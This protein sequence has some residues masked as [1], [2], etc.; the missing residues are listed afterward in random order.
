MQEALLR[1]WQLAP[2]CAGDGRPNGL[3]RFGLRA[4]HNLAVSELRRQRVALA[5]QHELLRQADATAIDWSPPDPLLRQL[6]ADCRER[7]PRQPRRALSARLDNAGAD[8]DRALAASLGMQRNTFLQNITRARRLLAD[9]LRR[10]G[11]DLGPEM[12]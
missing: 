1:C 9:C 4:A 2:R 7:L 6:I 5:E 10:A 3:L 11:V 12:P 8:A